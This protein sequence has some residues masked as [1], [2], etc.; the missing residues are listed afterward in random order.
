MHILS[1]LKSSHEQEKEGGRRQ[2]EQALHV[3]VMLLSQHQTAACGYS[4]AV[5]TKVPNI[6]SPAWRC[7]FTSSQEHNMISICNHVQQD[8]RGGETTFLTLI[9]NSRLLN[10]FKIKKNKIISHHYVICH[11]K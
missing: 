3:A 1:G 11:K 2:E 4:Q 7:F 8:I 9:I 5:S 10:S 6:S